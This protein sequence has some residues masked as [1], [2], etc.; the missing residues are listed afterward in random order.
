MKE[1][2][3]FWGHCCYQYGVEYKKFEPEIDMSKFI[4][5]QYIH[6]LKSCEEGRALELIAQ[7]QYG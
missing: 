2:L 5:V 4:V 1:R 7:M 3:Q 6:N